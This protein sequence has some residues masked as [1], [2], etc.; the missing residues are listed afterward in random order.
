MS[1]NINL[2]NAQLMNFVGNMYFVPILGHVNFI[3]K[4]SFLHVYFTNLRTYLYNLLLIKK[5]YY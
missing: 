3:N 2:T 5:K 4:L 1:Q